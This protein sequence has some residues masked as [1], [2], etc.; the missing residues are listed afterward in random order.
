MITDYNITCR[1]NRFGTAWYRN[2][3]TNLFYQNRTR[4]H[5]IYYKNS[6]QRTRNK[7]QNCL[8]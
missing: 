8:T 5:G 3:N 4:Y 6:I 2:K 1:Y 7:R